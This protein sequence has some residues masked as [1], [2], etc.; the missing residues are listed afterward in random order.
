MAGFPWDSNEAGSREA[1]KN[2]V[3][4]GEK[5]NEVHQNSSQCGRLVVVAVAVVERWMVVRVV[6]RNIVN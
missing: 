1:L 3:F 5:Q 6:F 2:M 4:N